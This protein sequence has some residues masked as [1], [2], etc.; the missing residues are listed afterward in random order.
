MSARMPSGFNTR[1]IS[2][3]ALSPSFPTQW[4]ALNKEK[5]IHVQEE[6]FQRGCQ[7]SLSFSFS[8]FYVD[9]GKGE[10]SLEQ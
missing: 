5:K 3:I 1:A 10:N 7:F 2:R 8:F 4:N 9:S 6:R